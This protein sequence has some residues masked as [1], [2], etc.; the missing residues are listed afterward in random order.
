M[1]K[2][3]GFLGL[4][5]AL[6][7]VLAVVVGTEERTPALPGIGATDRAGPA[8][9]APPAVELPVVSAGSVPDGMWLVGTDIPPG[10]YRTA[11]PYDSAIPNCYWERLRDASGEFDSIIANGNET[12][13][14]SVTLVTGEYFHSAGCTPWSLA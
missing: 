3:L 14:R 7:I 13:P 10:I 2:V 5:A 4:V 9:A 12:G 1:K 6:I 8:D 11:G